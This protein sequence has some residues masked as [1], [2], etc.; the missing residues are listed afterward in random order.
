MGERTV[1]G[2]ASPGADRPAAAPR[3]ERVERGLRLSGFIYGTILTL[4]VIVAGARGFPHSPSHIAAVVAIT[5]AVFWIAH[6]YAHAVGHSV[7]HEERIAFSELKLIARREA[8]MIGAAVPP[9][10]ALLLGA[11]GL[12]R[13]SVAIWAAFTAGLV[14]LGAQGLV[15]ARIERLGWLATTVV[16]T[17]NVALGLSLVALKLFI[18]H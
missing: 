1:A 13:E 11:L 8:S 6:V 5:S 18:N 10:V 2:T 17:A 16:V 7:A 15:V 14:V 3:A 9:V 4:S 12:V